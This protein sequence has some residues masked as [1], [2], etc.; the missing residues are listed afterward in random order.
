MMRLERRASLLVALC[1]LTSAATVAGCVTPSML[2]IND[3][4]QVIRCSAQGWGY[5]GAPMAQMAQESC[6]KDYK[7]V[8]YYELPD[9]V[10]GFI[11]EPGSTRI[12][13]VTAGSA[14][15]EVGVRAGDLVTQI[16]GRAIRNNRDLAD[17]LAHWKAGDML[18]ID[19]TRGAETLEF[20]PV[21]R[22]R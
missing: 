17:L 16:D 6:V 22:Q 3:Q 2:L 19:V 7:K 15:E 9:V 10:V 8:G 11:F 12:K 5:V 21:V 4:G 13:S 1:L 14:A 20:R 18:V